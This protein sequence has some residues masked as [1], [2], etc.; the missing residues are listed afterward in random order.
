MPRSE[1]FIPGFTPSLSRRLFDL[2]DRR[3]PFKD[4]LRRPIRR[5]V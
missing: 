5:R 2:H 1:T 4:P 3:L